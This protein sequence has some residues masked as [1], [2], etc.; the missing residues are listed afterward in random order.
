M[1]QMFMEYQGLREQREMTLHDVSVLRTWSLY[2][3]K[4]RYSA[5]C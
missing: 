1:W 3:G 5:F 2:V 4:I